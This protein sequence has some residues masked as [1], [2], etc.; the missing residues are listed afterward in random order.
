ML[1][2][3]IPGT[4]HVF[5]LAV[6][7]GVPHV[8]YASSSSVYGNN[9]KL[10]FV[11]TDRVDTPI[12]PYAM[13]K[14]ANELQ[15]YYYHHIYGLNSSGLRF[16]TVYGPWGRPDMALCIFTKKILAGE[17][18]AVNNGGKM[19]RDFTYVDDIVAGI[20]AALDRPYGCEIFNLGGD[21]SVE[22]THFIDVI[23]N[24]IGKKAIRN[25][26][27]MQPGD[28]PDT[29]AVIAKAQKLLDFKP[30]VHV[31]KGIP[32]FWDWYKRY[33]EVVEV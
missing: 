5:A 24:T 4:R 11:E 25:L 1:F 10:P 20:V 30:N 29:V 19:K 33:Y 28:V 26:L 6:K 31:E 22:L 16:F 7:Y 17:P 3:S 9:T 15:A 21:R 27:P 23:E 32:I 18:I 14:R 12:A 13:T 8:V 2:R